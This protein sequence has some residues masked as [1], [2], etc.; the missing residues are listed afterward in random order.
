MY[1]GVCSQMGRCERHTMSNFPPTKAD[2][3]KVMTVAPRS[4][5]TVLMMQLNC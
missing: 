3:M 1:C 4:D 2:A 5:T